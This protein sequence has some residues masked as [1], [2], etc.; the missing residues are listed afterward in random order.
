MDCENKYLS[1]AKG[2]L[3]YQPLVLVVIDKEWTLSQ[4]LPSAYCSGS[5]FV[6]KQLLKYSELFHNI[7]FLLNKLL[8]LLQKLWVVT[9]DHSWMGVEINKVTM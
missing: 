4:Q 8:W 5:Q 1:V 3:G 9:N 7:T 2:I 6:S